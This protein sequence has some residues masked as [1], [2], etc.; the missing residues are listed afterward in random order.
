LASPAPGFARVVVG[1]HACFVAE[2]DPRPRLFGQL[3][4]RRVLILA[5]A[6]D[7]LRILFSGAEQGPLATQAQLAQQA[8]HTAGAQLQGQLLAQQYPNHLARPKRELEAELK[9]IPAR[10]RLVKPLHLGRRDP[11]RPPL[12]C[13]RL[14]RAP[15][16]GPV[17]RQPGVDTT[18]AEPQ[19]FDDRFWTLPRLNLLDRPNPNLFKRLMVKFAGVPTR[20]SSLYQRLPT[21]AWLNRNTASLQAHPALYKTNEAYSNRTVSLEK[22]RSSAARPPF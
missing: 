2:E 5:P 4:N 16:S 6:L 13:P 22:E 20:H 9:R 8:S 12:E 17:Q 15:T 1:A 18:A 11:H 10:H 14:Q 3:L 19:C 7:S 21:Y